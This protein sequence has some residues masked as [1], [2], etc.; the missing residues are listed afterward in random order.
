MS[1]YI[2]IKEK[3][4][5]IENNLKNIDYKYGNFFEIK[6][7]N[8][9]EVISYLNDDEVIYIINKTNH[10]GFIITVLSKKYVNIFGRSEYLL[11]D[12]QQLSNYT[13]LNYYPLSVRSNFIDFP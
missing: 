8:F 11:E 1:E 9:R 13:N 5:K 2:D 6:Y 4:N 7:R 10:D 3:I 12:V